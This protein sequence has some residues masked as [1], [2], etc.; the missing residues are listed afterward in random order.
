MIT[1]KQNTINLK[2][3]IS[4]AIKANTVL[5]FGKPLVPSIINK[6]PQILPKVLFS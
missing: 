4:I 5:K 3:C 2:L 1:P 6:Y